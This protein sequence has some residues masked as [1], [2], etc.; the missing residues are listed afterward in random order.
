M[1]LGDVERL[2]A[3]IDDVL[4]ANRIGGEGAVQER[5]EID[6]RPLLE[7][8]V[9]RVVQYRAVSELAV[10]VEVEVEVPFKLRT[11][12]TS[13]ETIVRNLLDNAVKYSDA[14]VRIVVEARRDGHDGALIE[15][16]DQGIGLA[17]KDQQRIFER[18][19]RVD[20][21]NVRR[22]PGTGLGLF[23]VSALVRSLGGRVRASSGGPGQG[24]CM[25][26]TLP[27]SVP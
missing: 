1:M 24:T 4:M 10:E 17:A 16:R 20:M 11:D 23:V 26:V 12:R 6:V 18:F 14:P 25:Q 2:S 3:F 21:E 13:L 19:Y 27:R 7:R 15:V 5:E 22:R 8:C 9:A